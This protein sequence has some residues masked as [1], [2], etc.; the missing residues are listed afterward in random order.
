MKSAGDKYPWEFVE[1]KVLVLLDLYNGSARPKLKLKV[2]A[3][4]WAKDEH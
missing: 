2:K 4:A 3:L 1:D